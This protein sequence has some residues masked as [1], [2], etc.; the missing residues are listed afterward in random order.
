MDPQ[1]KIVYATCSVLPQENMEQALYFEEKFN[2]KIIKHFESFPTKDGMD[3][4]FG[5]VFAKLDITSL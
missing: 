1:G 3:G 2:L 5:A 4:F